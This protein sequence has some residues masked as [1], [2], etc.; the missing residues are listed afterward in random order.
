MGKE[1]FPRCDWGLQS[2]ALPCQTYVTEPLGI[3][4]GQFIYPFFQMNDSQTPNSVL[5]F[6]ALTCGLTSWPTP[7]H[8]G[9]H[10]TSP[11]HTNNLGRE[12]MRGLFPN[13]PWVYKLLVISSQILEFL[14][15][16]PV[17]MWYLLWSSGERGS[18]YICATSS[19]ILPTHLDHPGPFTV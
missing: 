5:G 9:F 13:M 8:P 18:L 16:F 12:W 10:H 11:F 17:S 7:K 15:S 2:A 1:L 19:L 14:A 3:S 6:C 4:H